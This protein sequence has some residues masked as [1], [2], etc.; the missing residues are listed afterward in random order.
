MPSAPLPCL[1]GAADAGE[2]GR[3][4]LLQIR[5]HKT[6]G[7]WSQGMGQVWRHF[8]LHYPKHASS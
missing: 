2:R 4:A 8:N 7:A 3:Q 6:P 5:Y 1:W